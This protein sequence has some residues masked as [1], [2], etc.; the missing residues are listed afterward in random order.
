[1]GRDVKIVIN[2]NSENSYTR[3]KGSMPPCIGRI[4]G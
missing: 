1:M 4:Q 3:I 2:E